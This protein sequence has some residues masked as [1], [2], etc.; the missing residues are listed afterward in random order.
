M[1]IKSLEKWISEAMD[2][3]DKEGKLTLMSLMHFQGAAQIEVHSKQFVSGT[4]YESAQVAAMFQ[5]KAETDAQNLI[6]MQSYVILA[7]YGGRKSAEAR[8][9]LLIDGEGGVKFNGLSTEGP[10]ATGSLQQGMRLTESIVKGVFGMLSN[11]QHY[12]QQFMSEM[13]H[14]NRQ[15]RQE[16]RDAW[17]VMKE[18]M[19]DQTKL[20]HEQRIKEMEI[21]AGLELKQTLMKAAP[22]LTNQLLGK[23]VFPQSAEDTAFIEMLAE[24]LDPE[25]AK[26]LLPLLGLSPTAQGALFNRLA[27]YHKEKRE[28]EERVQAITGGNTSTELGFTVPE[29]EAA[30]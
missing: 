6:G 21:R 14:E 12:Q 16:N 24:K 8:F 18:I 19:M 22:I 27:R 25:Q 13:A 17:S 20:Q 7:F 1:A 11:I 15:L 10:T 28:G 30:E 29:G 9:P 26:T 2:D 4:N 3:P 23:E 5:G